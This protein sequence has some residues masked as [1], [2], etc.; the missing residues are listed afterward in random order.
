[1][2]TQQLLLIGVLGFALIMFARS[3]WRHDLVAMAVLMF[4]VI[5]GL[6]PADQAFVG[7]GHPA[8]VTVAAVLIISQAL[9]N[10]GVVALV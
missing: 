10:A 4:S 5:L 1:M 6:V 7:F 3:R 9:N 2:D 8:V